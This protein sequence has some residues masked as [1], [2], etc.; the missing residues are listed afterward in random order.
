MKYRKLLIPFIC[1]VGGVVSVS[2]ATDLLYMGMLKNQLPGEVEDYKHATPDWKLSME[3]RA[4]SLIFYYWIQ[5][6]RFDMPSNKS[7]EIWLGSLIYQ[8]R[9][10][11][12]FER[13]FVNPDKFTQKGTFN[14]FSAAS[15]DNKSKIEVNTREEFNLL[16]LD[17]LKA[18][19][20][21]ELTYKTHYRIEN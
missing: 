15:A 1:L 16:N 12:A 7:I 17:F 8:I 18:V 14:K 3:A 9:R 19:Q 10:F 13:T 11:D 6:N 20:A 5:T 2:A 4:Q 21:Y